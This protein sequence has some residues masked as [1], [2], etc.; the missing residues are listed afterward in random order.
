MSKSI[1]QLQGCTLVAKKNSLQS[2]R[3]QQTTRTRI[4]TT[5]AAKWSQKE[6]PLD[7]HLCMTNGKHQQETGEQKRQN[8]DISSRLPSSSPS[9][10]FSFLSFFVFSSITFH[11]HSSVGWPF[12]SAPA[13]DPVNTLTSCPSDPGLPLLLASWYLINPCSVPHLDHTSASSSFINIS[14]PQLSGTNSGFAGFPTD[15]GQKK[16]K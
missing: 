16:S 6:V 3:K 9:F 7:F 8:K 10:P 13:H 4:Y 5:T 1:L 2:Q 15:K 12:P 11:F 14:T